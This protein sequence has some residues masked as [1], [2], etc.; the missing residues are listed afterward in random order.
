VVWE[1]TCCDFRPRSRPLTHSKWQLPQKMDYAMARLIASVLIV[2]ISTWP[3]NARSIKL[4]IYDDGLSCP[5]NCDAH[6]V[7]FPTDNGT[8]YAFRPGSTRSNPAKCIV[9]ED[10]EICFSDADATCMHAKYRGNGPSAGRFDFTPAFYSENCSRSD[11]PRA[12]RKQC[13]SLDRAASHLGYA[14]AINCFDEPDNPKCSSTMANAR[15]AQDADI[16]KRKRCLDIGQ[17]Q[18]NATQSDPKERRANACNYSD[19]RLGGKPGNHWRLLLPAAC[20]TGTFVDKFGLDCCSSNVRFA[21]A[22]H[23]ECKAFF[24]SK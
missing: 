22:N 24:P 8:R 15:A 13:N 1:I 10:C 4:T 18:Y 3:V 2:F 9:G 7:M 16:P 6:V 14:E 19:L 17:S 21:A 20:R 11:V 5:G 23:P 12:L